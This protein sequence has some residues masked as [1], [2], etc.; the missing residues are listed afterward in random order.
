MTTNFEGVLITPHLKHLLV[1]C[2]TRRTACGKPMKSGK[3]FDGLEYWNAHAPIQCR[4]CYREWVK[5]K[6]VND[7]VAE[8]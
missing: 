4:S 1:D 5:M 7:V 6:G 8:R 3:V 2:R